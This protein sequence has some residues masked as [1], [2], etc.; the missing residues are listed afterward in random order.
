VLG[1]TA[2]GKTR[3]AVELARAFSG[4]IVSADSRQVYRGMDLGTGKDLDE[5]AAAGAQPPVPYH[6]IDVAD[7]R[8][9]FDLHRYLALARAALVGA[10]G[11]GRLPLVAGGSGLYLR[12]L[13][14]G[15]RL[16]GK[17]RD[18][19]REQSLAACPDTELLAELA[20]LAPDLAARADRSQ[21]RRL[22]RAVD[23][24]RTRETAA[25]AEPLPRLRPLLL[26][27]YWPR[28]A[29][30]ARIAARLTARLAA[31]LV[32]EVRRLHIAGVPWQRLEEFGLEYR[33]AARHLQGQ[34]DAA[35][36]AEALLAGIR[37]LARRQDIWFRRLERDGH[38][39]H[40]LPGGDTAAARHLVERFLAGQPLPTPGLRLSD[41]YYGPRSHRPLPPRP[42]PDGTPG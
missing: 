31:G 40:W 36:M 4:E 25:A 27:P 5:Y 13:L 29:L 28:A 17:A 6:M 16:D 22:L 1:P 39:I 7:P 24:A 12:A 26:G 19:E 20:R 9:P 8:E 21:R 41:T 23:I 35:A 30:H 42:A 34:L 15:Y 10:A 2:S 33:F 18:D 14:E 11:R 38:T 37:Q 3:L 32:D